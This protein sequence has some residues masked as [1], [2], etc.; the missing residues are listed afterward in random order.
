MVDIVDEQGWRYQITV[1][2]V[3]TDSILEVNVFDTG[4]QSG[5][6]YQGLYSVQINRRVNETGGLSTQQNQ[7]Q[8]SSK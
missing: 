8:W 1:D 5:F 6:E 4:L 7:R 3:P 2:V